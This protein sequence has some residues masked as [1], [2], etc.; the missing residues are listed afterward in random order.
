MEE[1]GRELSFKWKIHW[2]HCQRCFTASRPC[3]L[4]H[5]E[6]VSVVKIEKTVT[7][8]DEEKPEKCAAGGRFVS[9]VWTSLMRNYSQTDHKPAEA[10]WISLY[11][12]DTCTCMF[13]AHSTVISWSSVVTCSHH[14]KHDGSCSIQIQ[15][16]QL[17]MVL[18]RRANRKSTKK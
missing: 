18:K 4:Y 3:E 2:I 12:H 17:Q 14:P 15:N 6:I 11:I 7:Q 1:P 16:L 13:C 8:I 10:G 9:E 5:S